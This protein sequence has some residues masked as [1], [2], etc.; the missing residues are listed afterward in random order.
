MN[1][2]SKNSTV[3][4][5]RKTT[6][7]L[8]KER[9]E[10]KRAMQCNAQN[11]IPA[12]HRPPL[13]SGRTNSPSDATPQHPTAR[14]PETA[15]HT[16]THIHAHTYTHTHTRTHAHAR[17][18]ARTHNT[19]HTHTHTYIQ[20]S[21]FAKAVVTGHRRACSSKEQKTYE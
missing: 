10:K 6:M 20:R 2:R 9:K 21:S 15:K 17:A 1:G 14:V 8:I 16:R 19:T 11:Y 5:G 3:G 18:H 7:L 12:T 13:S 4:R